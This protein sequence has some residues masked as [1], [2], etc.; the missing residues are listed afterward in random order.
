M[1]DLSNHEDGRITAGKKERRRAKEEE[2]NN[3]KQEAEEEKNNMHSCTLVHT[4][5]QWVRQ[6]TMQRAWE[7]TRTVFFAPLTTGVFMM[8]GPKQQ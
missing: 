6:L 5:R 1:I 8:I 3:L 7:E 4:C 2:N